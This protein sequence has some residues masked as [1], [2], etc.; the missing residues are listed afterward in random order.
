M[1]GIFGYVGSGNASSIVFAGLKNLEYRGY[2][3]W[4]VASIQSGQIKIQKQVGKIGSSHLSLTESSIALGHTRWATHGGVTKEN[5]HP[6]TDCHQQLVVVHN[7]IIEN[8]EELKAKLLKQGHQFISDTDT[9]VFSHLVEQAQKSCDFASAVSSSFSEIKGLNTIVVMN[10]DGGL[11]ACKHG[12]PLM[13]AVDPTG[14]I[15]LSSDLPSLLSYTKQVAILSDQEIVVI[16]GGKLITHHE[17]AQINMA[18]SIAD[19]ANFPHYYLKEIHDQPTSLLRRSQ[20]GNQEI[21]KA[22]T[23]LSQARDVYLIGCGTA[24]YSMLLATYLLGHYNKIHATAIP[25]NEFANFVPLLGPGSV[26]M[27]ASQSG[28]TI[29]AIEAIKLSKL[30]GAKTIGLINVPGSTLS[31]EV[32]I[33]ISLLAG[34]E[35]AVVSSKAFSNMLACAYLMTGHQRELVKTASSIRNMFENTALTKQFQN[36]AHKLSQHQSLFVIGRGINYP[37][38]LEGALKLKEISYL[39]AEG[40]AG[41][42]LKHGVIALIEQGTPVFVVIGNDSEKSNTLSSAIELKAR[43]AWVIGISPTNE[44]MFDDWIKVPDLS[45]TSPLVN[46]IPFQFLGYYLALE[47]RLDPDMPRNLAKSVTVK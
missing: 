30:R 38:A 35:K 16:K 5:S 15:Y 20:A 32:D 19:K 8:Y 9:E 11:V 43:G 34:I 4:G 33:C 22:K 10:K 7:G 24:Y 44:T 28:E 25:A 36:L 29:D 21:I 31:R 6:H 12:S 17:L 23:L 39:H 45:T 18:A 26:V 47:K 41:G 46:I 2:D 1:C 37:L 13:V 42:E 27:V 40:L 14:A 3:S